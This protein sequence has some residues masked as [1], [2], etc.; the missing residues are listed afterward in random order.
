MTSDTVRVELLVLDS[1]TNMTSQKCIF[2]SIFSKPNA[3]P[4]NTYVINS[5]FN[6][7]ARK[8]FGFGKGREEMEATGP[9]AETLTNKNPGP[10]SYKLPSTLAN[11]NYRIRGRINVIDK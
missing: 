5:E 7:S 11:S 2:C 6:R 3:P 8:G 4:P 10:G 9:M 1:E